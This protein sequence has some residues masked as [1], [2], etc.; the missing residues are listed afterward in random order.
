MKAFTSPQS[1]AKAEAAWAAAQRLQQFGYAEIS[2]DVSASTELATHIVRGWERDGKIRLISAVRR[3][4]A[5]RKV[6]EVVPDQEIKPAP[7]MGD[8]F[9][10]MWTCMRKLSSFTAVDLSAHCA[11]AVAVEDARTY[12]RTLLA[13]G[14]LR[15]VQK[16]VPNRREAIY[17]LVNAT[18]VKA[19]RAR[20]VVCIVDANLGRITPLAEA[21]A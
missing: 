9:D 16:A 11:A 10:Q 17:R 19:P 18:G 4:G 12:C 15:V 13:G 8:G 3:G 21:G 1:L 2:R 20:R 7:V 14:Y 5:A 6:Y